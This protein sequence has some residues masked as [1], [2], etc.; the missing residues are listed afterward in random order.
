MV[1]F[2]F[3][4]GFHHA[5]RP[6]RPHVGKIPD[7]FEDASVEQLFAQTRQLAELLSRAQTDLTH[8]NAATLHHLLAA[9]TPEEFNA[10]WDFIAE[11]FDLLYSEPDYVASLLKAILELAVRGKLTRR[12]SS[13]EPASELLKRI[14]IEKARLVEAGELRE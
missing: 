2:N 1:Q 6:R 11:H 10:Q 12:D 13:D 7:I 9:D 5:L 4:V 14:Q 8:L 3:G